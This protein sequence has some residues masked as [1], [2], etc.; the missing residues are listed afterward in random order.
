MVSTDGLSLAATIILLFPMMYFFIATLTFF[1][2]KMT[3]PVATWLLRGLFN[4]YFRVVAVL[5]A[6][7]ALAFLRAG[8]PLIM[9]ELALVVALAIAA[10]VWF[11]SRMDAQIAARDAGDLTAPRNLRR[12]HV[13]GILYNVVQMALIIA[14]IPTM[15]AEAA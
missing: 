5:C 13:G 4:V 9:A 6:L 2:A 3:D 14:S 1:L 7:G 15:F 12:L 8:K 10:R 11:V